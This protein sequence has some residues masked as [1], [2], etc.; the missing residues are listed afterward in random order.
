M[1]DWNHGQ[2]EEVRWISHKDR[3]LRDRKRWFCQDQCCGGH[4]FDRCDE[5]ARCRQ[6]CEK[7][8]C[9]RISPYDH[10]QPSQGLGHRMYDAGEDPYT[11]KNTT[12]L[13]NKLDLRTQAELDDFEVEI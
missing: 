4:S 13:I 5:R 9:G 1:L 10:Q 2:A 7:A 8:H 6:A 11:Y 12:V 3:S